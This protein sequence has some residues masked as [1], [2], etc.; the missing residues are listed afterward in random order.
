MAIGESI[1]IALAAIT[2]TSAIIFFAWNVVKKD[3]ERLEKSHG[4]IEK[5]LRAVEHQM[6]FVGPLIEVLKSAGEE[7]VKRMMEVP[8]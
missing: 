2:L 8:E 1:A 5:R 3:I 4:E 6:V 7:K